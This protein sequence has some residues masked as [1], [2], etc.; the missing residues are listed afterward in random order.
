MLCTRLPQPSPS[1]GPSCFHF[2]RG[3]AAGECR[4]RP[5]G[6]QGEGSLL[7]G[8]AREPPEL[9]WRPGPRPGRDS[10]MRGWAVIGTR[11]PGPFQ[12]PLMPLPSQGGGSR[13]LLMAQTWSL[14]SQAP[15]SHQT[16]RTQGRQ[17]RALPFL[18]LGSEPSLDPQRHQRGQPLAGGGGHVGTGR[19]QVVV[20]RRQLPSVCRAGGASRRHRPGRAPVDSAMR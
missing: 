16:S 17:A 6:A 13:A 8:L 19:R 12:G 4:A 11:S 10:E 14:A 3:I 15:S 1:R 7:A 5:W 2:P 20:L 18:T 9:C